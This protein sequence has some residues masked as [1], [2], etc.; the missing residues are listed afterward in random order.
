MTSRGSSGDCR[1]RQTPFLVASGTAISAFS[2]C[3][4]QLFFAA[5]NLPHDLVALREEYFTHGL[6]RI[7][8][9]PDPIKEFGIWFT[10]AVE[11]GI[12]EMNAIALATVAE[13]GQ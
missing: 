7:D 12:N 1:Q 3:P 4:R 13:N 11:V 9:D 6:R 8:L 10:A 5:V 2:R